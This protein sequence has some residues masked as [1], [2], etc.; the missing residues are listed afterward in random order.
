MIGDRRSLGV[1]GRQ[2]GRQLDHTDITPVA[3]PW[4]QAVTPKQTRENWLQ[5]PVFIGV[6]TYYGCRAALVVTSS[7]NTTKKT[8]N[9]GEVR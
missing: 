4:L 9:N 5:R 2:L 8:E 6:V 3:Y 1:S 7:T